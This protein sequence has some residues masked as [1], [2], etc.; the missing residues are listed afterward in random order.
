MKAIF[1]SLMLSSMALAQI[2]SGSFY[3]QILDESGALVSNARVTA[4]QKSTGFVRSV[5]SDPSGSYRVSNLAPGTYSMT[6]ERTG[7]RTSVASQVTLEINQQARLD[8]QLKVGPAH[9]SVDVTA[10]V[11]QLQTDDNS[12][13]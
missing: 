12:E 3:G 10:S 2:S 7:F 4:Q 6:V 9:D 1:L 13:G 11:S 8:F 5:V